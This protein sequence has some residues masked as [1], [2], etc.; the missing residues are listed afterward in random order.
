[1]PLAG[2]MKF[3][4]SDAHHF[5]VD[6]VIAEHNAHMETSGNSF[7]E[8]DDY[9]RADVYLSCLAVESL[10]TSALDAKVFIRYEHYDDF[11]DLP[12]Q[13][14]FMMVL[15]ICNASTD[16]DIEAATKSFGKLTLADYPTENIENFA[17]KS[18]RLI[19]I[20]QGG[21]ALPYNLGSD[22]LNRVSTTACPYFNGKVISFLD[23]V[24]VMEDKVGAS[25]ELMMQDPNYTTYGPIAL[26]SLLQHEYTSS[27][28]RPSG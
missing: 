11:E 27:I 14:Y 10:M 1:M 21:Y 6:E 19:K 18:P 23:S 4:N 9:E 8:Y 28:Q 24:T 13:V 3:L 5:T 25:R 22:L 15:D 17:T 2:S 12:L 7:K 26:C 20:M 16:H